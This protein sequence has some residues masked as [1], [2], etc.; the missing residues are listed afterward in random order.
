MLL[1]RARQPRDRQ[2]PA[3]DRQ[4]QFGRNRIALDTAMAYAREHVGPPLQA[5]FTRQRLAHL[6]A[7][8]GNFEVEGIYRQQRSALSNRHE[9]RGCVAGKIVATHQLSAELSGVL[10]AVRAAHGTAISA[11]AMRRRSP[12]MM[13]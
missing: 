1:D 5:H 4:Q 12:I 2:T 10:V 11:A 7:H 8:T 3:P 6:L 13:L 9:Q